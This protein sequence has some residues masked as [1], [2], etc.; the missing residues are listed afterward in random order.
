GAAAVAIAHLVLLLAE[1]KGLEPRTAHHLGGVANHRL[2][3]GDAR[4]AAGFGEIPFNL[5]Q[6]AKPAIEASG[7]HALRQ[8]HVRR[9]L[10]RIADHERRYTHP[11]KP[12]PM[13]VARLPTLTKCGRSNPC[14]PSSAATMEPSVGYFTVPAGT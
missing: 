10:R 5:L 11:R 3:V 9:H 8:R 7:S 1:V 13:V 4:A 6:Q 2:V 14:G 12:E